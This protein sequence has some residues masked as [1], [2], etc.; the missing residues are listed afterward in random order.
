MTVDTGRTEAALPDKPAYEDNR[1]FLVGLAR[2]FAGALIFSLPMLMTMEMWWIGFTMNSWRLV[3]LLVLLIPLLVGLSVVS[4][5]KSTASLRDDIADAFVTI[6]VAVVM[7]VVI[8]GI[9]KVLS[10]DMP[11]REVIGKIALQSFPAAIG[12]MLARDQL[13]QKSSE[14]MQRQTAMSYPQ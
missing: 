10:V 3:L 1:S 8:L 4:G 11:A 9:F 5:F 12:A 6:A 14:S 2:A 13:G 7:S